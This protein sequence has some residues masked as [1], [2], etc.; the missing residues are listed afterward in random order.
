MGIERL[1]GVLFIGGWTALLV[2]GAIA[3]SGGTV[4]IGSGAIGSLA[5]AA[6]LVLLGAG[7]VSL[8]VAGPRSLGGRAV[9]VGLVILGIGLLSSLASSVMTAG[10]AGDPLESG[11]IVITL[12]VGGLAVMLGVLVTVASLLRARGW[13]RAVGS[14][15]LAGLLVVVF[16]GML[17]AGTDP[18]PDP[19]SVLGR[20]LAVLGAVGIVL[21]GA[22]LGVLAAMGDRSAP[23]ASL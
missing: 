5:L 15:L 9:R 13:P 8:G 16:G 3:L 23:A 22:G 11:P 17:G 1:G 20:V 19:L 14:V 12:L 18:S 7:A 6:A 10:F 2:A 21:A 4:G